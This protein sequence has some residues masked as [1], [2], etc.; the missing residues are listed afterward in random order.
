MIINYKVSIFNSKQNQ[1]NNFIKLLTKCK[2]E[3]NNK[4]DYDKKTLLHLLNMHG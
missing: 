3:I 2:N 1:R 4:F